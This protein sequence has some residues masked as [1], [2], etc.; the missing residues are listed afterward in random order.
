MFA[1][2]FPTHFTKKQ[3][4]HTTIY[5]FTVSLCS[6]LSLTVCVWVSVL[7]WQDWCK[8]ANQGVL[9]RCTWQRQHPKLDCFAYP[10]A[11][12]RLAV[13]HW[14][15]FCLRPGYF[16]TVW[17]I[18][19]AAVRPVSEM[20]WSG[21]FCHA[22]QPALSARKTQSEIQVSHLFLATWKQEKLLI[23]NSRKSKCR[24]SLLPL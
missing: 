20:D 12:R 21:A 2:L 13:W 5:T 15:Q 23:I 1:K 4:Y 10:F 11:V 14:K 22:D 24:M 18:G 9:H 17:V 16:S 3:L 8:T 7:H 6:C 19:S